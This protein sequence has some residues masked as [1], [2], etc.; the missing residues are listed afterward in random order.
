[1]M[2]AVAGGKASRPAGVLRPC[3]LPSS[4]REAFTIIELIV[5]IGIFVISA[6]LMLGAMFG[7]TEVFRRGEAARQA[8]DE[9]TAVIAALQEDLSRAV[10]SRLRDGV[11]AREWGRL[12]VDSDGAGNCRLGLVTENPDR[13]QVRWVPRPSVSATARALVG[14]RKWVVWQIIAATTPASTAADAMLVRE[15][16][17]ITEDG[18]V[19]DVVGNDMAGLTSSTQTPL[20]EDIVTRGCLHFG[21]WVELAEAHRLVRGG[22]GGPEFLWE[23]KDPLELV[24]PFANSNFDTRVQQGG[25]STGYQPFYPQPDALRVSLV[26]TGGGRFATR[27][28]L[29]GQLANGATEARISGIKA[30]PTTGGSL[31]CLSDPSNPSSAE[32]IRYDDFRSSRVTGLKRGQLRT[33]DGTRADRS[34]VLA[35]QPFS[36]VVALPR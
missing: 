14:V 21:A 8:G 1:M 9:A 29:I 18:T 32:W 2:H 12:Y 23:S 11:P 15:E 5:S 7:A 10:P 30:L 25:G 26:L 20:R 22:V 35:G 19:I 17:D 6:T 36:L 33:T 27:G 16:W 31:L 28:T 24:F 34:L 4:Q 3:R 13:S